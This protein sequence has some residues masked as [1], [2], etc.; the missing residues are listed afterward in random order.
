MTHA[1]EEPHGYLGNYAAVYQ[2]Y[3]SGKKRR[4]DLL[5]AVNGAVFAVISGV[6]ALGAAA[7]AD[8]PH[9][10]IAV[11]MFF[12]T[13]IFGYDIWQFGMRMRKKAEDDKLPVTEGIFARAGRIVLCGI[14]AILMSGWALAAFPGL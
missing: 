13:A 6:S 4:Y 5:F 1:T 8:F 9:Q 10:R 3:E 7:S 2:L 12:L 11:G 14:C